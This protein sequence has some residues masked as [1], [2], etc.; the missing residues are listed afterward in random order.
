MNWSFHL[1]RAVFTQCVAN[2]MASHQIRF[3]R[4]R[5]VAG[6]PYVISGFV[7][8][9][10]SPN[11]FLE[12]SLICL[13]IIISNPIKLILQEL[14]SEFVGVF[15]SVHGQYKASSVECCDRGK[16]LMSSALW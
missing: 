10:Q 13:C 3:C 5:I 6:S 8:D 4:D 16:L 14:V 2:D 7:W 1:A 15:P 12:T 9:P 11:A